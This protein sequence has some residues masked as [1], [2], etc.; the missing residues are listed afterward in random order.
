[1]ARRQ[2][3]LAPSS[4]PHTAT[5]GYIDDLVYGPSRTMTLPYTNG[6]LGGSVATSL[7]SATAGSDRFVVKLPVATSQWRIKIRNWDINNTT[8]TAATLKKLIFGVH[9]R[10]TAT[11]AAETGSFLGSAA[12]TIVATDQTI[13][14]TSGT[15][16][17][18]P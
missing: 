5:K 7:A 3:G 11:P 16:Y 15:W 6:G 4:P 10:Q 1:M 8:K 13:P 2:L 9:A 14:G 12:T 17:T 18:G